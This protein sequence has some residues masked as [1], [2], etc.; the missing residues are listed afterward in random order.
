[1]NTSIAPRKH[2]HLMWVLGLLSLTAAVQLECGEGQYLKQTRFTSGRRRRRRS[3]FTC[4]SCPKGRYMG[5][6]G[7]QLG[8]CRWCASGM[9]T[10]QTGASAC[11]LSVGGSKCPAGTWGVLGS[12]APPGPC[13]DCETGR[14]QPHAGEGGCFACPSGTFAASKA[15]SVC[16]VRVAGGCPAGQWGPIASRSASEAACSDC[17]VDHFSVHPGSEGCEPCPRGTHQPKTGQNGCVVIPRCPRYSFWEQ[18]SRSCEERHE[19]LVYLVVSVWMAWVLNLGSCCC[20]PQ[21]PHWYRDV[22]VP[23]FIIYMGVGIESTRWGGTIPD[24]NFWVM[25]SFAGLGMSAQLAFYLEGLY[26]WVSTMSCGSCTS[27]CSRADGQGSGS[28]G[29]KGG[30]SS[31]LDRVTTLA[32]AHQVV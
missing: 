1:M 5:L 29:K 2:L 22:C 14:W 18:S 3:S 7:H 25:V 11:K 30:G 6:S 20:M 28:G 13:V 17:A 27:M 8:E 9:W 21:T 26:H 24:A 23:N 12:T 32:S 15:A 31:K 4:S 19:Y 16:T 10:D